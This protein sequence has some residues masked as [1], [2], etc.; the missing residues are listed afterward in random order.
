MKERS[1]EKKNARMRLTLDEAYEYCRQMSRHHAKTFYLASM[2]LPERQRRPI[3]AIYALLRTVDDIV[4]MAEV[5]LSKGLITGEE[6]R[7]MLEDWKAR[8]RACYAGNPG[9]DPIMMAWH[10]TLKRYPVPIELPFELIEGVAMDISFK[11]FE[12]FDE[13]YGYCYKV[14]SVVG[15]MTSE[16]FG[17]SDKRALDHAV[18]L[19]IAMQLTNILRDIGED[20]DRGRIYLPMEDLRR[21]DCSIEEFLQKTM[22]RKFVDLMK[23]QVERARG[24]YRSAEQGIPMLHRES[25]FAVSLSSLNYGN[26]LTAI[27][28]N[29][30]DV[31]SK[32]AYRSFFQKISTIPAVW[33]KTV[34]GS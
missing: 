6:I 32:R 18:E 12:T 14:A 21:F 1:A 5:K 34:T 23:F 2:F 11:P 25:R 31:F 33:F 26:I 15:L 3:F 22:N 9:D 27:E 30:Y 7:K 19:G 8:L 28:E 17:Y 24:Y 4:D 20:I 16:I 13:L 29:G 10:D